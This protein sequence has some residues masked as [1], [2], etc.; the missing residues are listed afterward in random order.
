MTLRMSLLALALGLATPA[1]AQPAPP[2]GGSATRDP[3][4]D[5]TVSRKA[6]ES[7]AAARF[8]ALD[9]D[10]DGVLSPAELAAAVPARPGAGARS[11]GRGNRA[12]GWMA[13]MLDANG[14][15]RITRDEF[16][17]GMLR[18]FDRMDANHDGQLTSA[19]RQ[20]AREEMR[21]R[22]EERIRERMSGGGADGGD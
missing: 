6:A 19:E 7:Q 22:M 9:T 11:G 14:D 18:R 17:A 20:A 2:P 4:G 5:A 13:R 21:A 1:I 16:V 8:D 15:G 12:G 3:L 10:K